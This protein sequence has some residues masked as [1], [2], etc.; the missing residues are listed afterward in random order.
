MLLEGFATPEA[1]F[2]KLP[3]ELTNCMDKIASLAELKVVLYILRHTWGFQ[4]YDKPKKIT[5]D[6]FMNGRKTKDGRRID[7][8]IGMSKPSVINGLELAERDG[9]ITVFSD[10]SDPARIK[11]FYMIRTAG[12]KNVDPDVKDFDT[13]GKDSLHRTEKETL[14]RNSEKEKE[15]SAIAEEAPKDEKINLTPIQWIIFTL[16]FKDMVATEQSDSEK[17]ESVQSEKQTSPENSEDKKTDSS[18]ID[19]NQ[20]KSAVRKTFKVYGRQENHIINLLLSRSKKGEWA[21]CNLETPIATAQEV[22]DFG[23][24]YATTFN[25]AHP[26]QKPEKIQSHFMRFQ[27]ERNSNEMSNSSITQSKP[28]KVSE[29]K[30]AAF[31]AKYGGQAS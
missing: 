8:G 3:H 4:E 2:S 22:L 27:A 7:N 14:E 12:V 29:D 19:W 25:N 1:N 6:E 11:K 28:H 10:E 17:S 18:K 5:V 21:K 26:P 30:L 31:Y 23:I 15:L 16:L 9:L 20:L 24:W 13:S